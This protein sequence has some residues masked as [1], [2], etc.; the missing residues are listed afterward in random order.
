MP[1]RNEE[2]SLFRCLLAL[3]RQKDE[4]GWPLD[5]DIF[6]VILLIN[7]STD[8]TWEVARQFQEQH[9]SLRLRV[10]NIRLDENIHIGHLR[11]ALMGVACQR[12]SSAQKAGPALIL[13]TDADTEVATDWVA[14]NLREIEDG[15]EAVGGRICLNEESFRR[16]PRRVQHLRILDERYRTLLAWLE[17]RCDP[18]QHDRW[19][20]H[21]HHFGGSLAVTADA[22][23]RVGGL[24]AE[25][26]LEDV[27]FYQ[28]LQRYDVPFRHSPDV[29][30]RTSARLRGRVD[31]GLSE[32]LG[33]WAELNG[34]GTAYV[35]APHAWRERFLL[36]RDYRGL[37]VNGDNRQSALQFAEENHLP[38]EMVG[39]ALEAKYFG[40]G[41][42]VIE[43]HLPSL[44]AIPLEDAVLQLNSLAQK[45]QA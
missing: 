19:P 21:Y 38:A 28:R 9:P 23:R 8:G 33:K 22:Y 24:P 43:P 41:W 2:E 29:I 40:Q 34:D 36:R 39:K 27:A 1:A 3:L 5:A 42:Q 14:K 10:V 7:N 15:A 17:D 16:L 20:R 4:N 44:P 26:V 35:E 11:Q 31:I 30:V 37:R 18:V 25:P 6:E 45:I 32:Q 12:L 13:S